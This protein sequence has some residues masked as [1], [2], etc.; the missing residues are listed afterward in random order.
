MYEKAFP[1]PSFKNSRASD[2]FSLIELLVAI[3]VAL[4]VMASVFGL[5]AQAQKGSREGQAV[6]D[7]QGQAR[8]ALEQISRDIIQAGANLPPEF[9][10]FTPLEINRPSSPEERLI[11]IVGAASDDAIGGGAVRVESF[12]G[13][14]AVMDH[15]PAGMQPGDLVVLFDGKPTEGAW[16]F[17]LVQGS[18]S[19]TSEQGVLLETAPG[20]TLS[21]TRDR[22]GDP[23]TLPHFIASYNRSFP[24]DGYLT[25]VSVVSYRVDTDDSGANVLSRS[26]NWGT[27]QPVATVADL[28]FRF[29]VGDTTNGTQTNNSNNSNSGRRN[30]PFGAPPSPSAP[31]F[32]KF[33]A[34]PPTN[35]DPPNTGQDLVGLPDPPA[36][37]PLPSQPV[38]RGDLVSSVRVSVSAV[39]RQ[40]RVI[41]GT[42][43]GGA[44]GR[45]LSTSVSARNVISHWAYLP[46]AT[47][48]TPPN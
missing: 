47:T 6:A 5:L 20:A 34:D 18:F 3:A 4:I 31:K 10:A 42:E 11:E 17:G 30:R 22:N 32:G 15:I 1:S 29:F 23:A 9:P 40:Q 35:N 26:Q 19:D 8:H 25:R 28:Q 41:G 37:Q 7:A 2:G 24:S 45:S 16:I 46:D 33:F 38:R 13:H 14:R 21:G 43:E 48:S 39:S 44:V 36:P 12:D 27:P